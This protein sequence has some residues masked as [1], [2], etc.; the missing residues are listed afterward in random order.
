MNSIESELFD[1]FKFVDKICRE[2]FNA[3]KGIGAYL[4][5]MEMTPMSV[6]CRIPQWENDYKKLKHIRWIRNQLAHETGYVEC[7]AEDVNWLKDFHRRLLNQQDPLAYA[8]RIN[9]ANQQPKRAAKPQSSGVNYAQPSDNKQK[10]SSLGLGIALAVIAIEA[11][12]FIVFY[13]LNR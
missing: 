11:I 7:T 5:Q 6:N 13:F 1:E 4:Y 3:E 10:S 9:R 8:D 2:M 12:F